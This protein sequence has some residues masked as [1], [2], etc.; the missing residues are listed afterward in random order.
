M[1]NI[2]TIEN[3]FLKVSVKDLGAE[4]CGIFN[5]KT[6]LNLLWS[7]DEAWWNRTAPLL[8]PSIGRSKD[9]KY[10][11]NNKD[12]TMTP[13]GFARDFD[14]EMV[15]LEN[16]AVTHKLIPNDK[17]KEMYPFDFELNVT[18]RLIENKLSIEWAVKNNG[19]ET[20]PFSIGGHA[21]FMCS[22][23]TGNF[24]KSSLIFEQDQLTYQLVDGVLVA[25]DM[26]KMDLNNKT[27]P[28]TKELFE[29]DVLIFPQGDITKV[30]I[31]EDGKPHLAVVF[32]GFPFVGIWTKPGAP[33][34]CIEPWY[35]VADSK[36]ADCII[37]HKRGIQMLKAGEEFKV[38]HTVEAL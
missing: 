37:E 24:E 19:D 2:R 20:M 13:H 5:K 6:G 7:G 27:L 10:I 17:T 28:I 3:D 38:A 26:Y 14:F 21:A 34:V 29:K 12:Y 25:P 9:N 35:G 1:S 15:S 22:P 11:Y 36:D 4:L 8:F 31:A 18:H 23:A 32:R 16:T 33:F 30:T